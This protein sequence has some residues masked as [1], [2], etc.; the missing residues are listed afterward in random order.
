MSDLEF[1]SKEPVDKG[2]SCDKKYCVNEV[3]VKDHP[4]SQKRKSLGYVPYAA[5]GC[6]SRCSYVQVR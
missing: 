6:G 4:R 5:E 1:I 2:W 3:S